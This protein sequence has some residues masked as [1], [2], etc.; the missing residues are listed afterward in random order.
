MVAMISTAPQEFQTETEIKFLDTV[1]GMQDNM[2]EVKVMIGN[3]V[4]L[5]K[6]DTGAEVT[7]LSEETWKRL[8]MAEPL[9]QPDA[10]LGGP[11]RTQL[12]VLG[13]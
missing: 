10:F 6:V 8:K 12:T 3:K 5:F 9:L 7:V 4:I 2:W 11:D 13:H 1:E